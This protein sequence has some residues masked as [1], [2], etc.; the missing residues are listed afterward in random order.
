MAA[1]PQPCN[2]GPGFLRYTGRAEGAV[3]SQTALVSGLQA[4]WLSLLGWFPAQLAACRRHGPA[5]AHWGDLR[6]S[7]F[8]G[9]NADRAGGRR[10]RRSSGELRRE[11][12]LPAGREMAAGSSC[13]LQPWDSGG[14]ACQTAHASSAT[15]PFKR[16]TNSAPRAF[17]NPPIRHRRQKGCLIPT[18]SPHCPEPSRQLEKSGH[19]EQQGEQH[20]NPAAFPSPLSLAFLLSQPAQSVPN[21]PEC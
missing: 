3:E 15:G 11:V 7:F 10:G 9:A 5:G 4:S 6:G 20:A 17:Q 12:S 21:A 16:A 19:W 1:A 2:R 8:A 18:L 14:G 13:L